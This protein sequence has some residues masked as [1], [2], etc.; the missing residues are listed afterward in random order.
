MTQAPPSALK[1]WARK[2][3][4]S[5]SGL[6]SMVVVDHDDVMMVVVNDDHV[7]VMVV[8]MHDH[9]LRK[10]GRRSRR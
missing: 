1:R 10:R 9:R 3:P 6:A 8:V 4:S 2:R 5:W 7:V